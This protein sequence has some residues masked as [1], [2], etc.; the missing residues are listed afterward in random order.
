MRKEKGGRG[1]ET[2]E[3]EERQGGCHLS[4]P[5]EAGNDEMSCRGRGKKGRTRRG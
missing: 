2:D 5:S 3:E 1:E 4:E